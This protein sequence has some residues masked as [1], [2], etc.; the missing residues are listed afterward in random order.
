ML[1]IPMTAVKNHEDSQ[2]TPGVMPEFQRAR[3]SFRHTAD[4]ALFSL[5]ALGVDPDR[6][7]IRRA[8]RGW[9]FGRVVG[10][11]PPADRKLSSEDIVISVAG[12]AL[13]DRLPTGL[14]DRGTPNEAGIDTLLLAFDDPS[15]K[16]SC[17]VRQG[18]LYFDLRPDNPTGCARWIRLFGIA[19][20]V[21]PVESWYALA[22]FLPRLH[23]CS[24]QETGI[25]LGAKL[26][27][28][29]DIARMEWGWRRTSLDDE[30]LTRVGA[31]STRLGV[32]FIVGR[33]VED[34]AVLDIT[35]GPMTL[36]EYRRHQA[37]EMQKQL[38]MVFDLV[39]P[40]H[41]VCAVNWLIGNPQFAPRLAADED[42][43]VLGLNMHL[44]KKA[45]MVGRH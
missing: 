30:A 15:E 7:T 26:L 17:Y 23:R 33:A 43:A 44:G 32:D 14:R 25:R 9:T 21:W 12:D 13:F 6:I 28:G 3:H 2:A 40:C 35:F 36:A 27:L 31:V 4:S 19:P 18:G 10:Q 42:N 8:G 41:L 1:M 38:R 20:E 16:A 45:T 11:D 39:L 37:K 5:L 34:E 29:L 22:R 24:G